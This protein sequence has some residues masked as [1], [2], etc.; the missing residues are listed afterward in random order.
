MAIFAEVTE[1]ECINEHVYSHK[2]AQK[3]VQ[4]KE[5]KKKVPLDFFAVTLPN[6]NRSSK[7][8]YQHTQQ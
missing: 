7:F 3:K 4:K 1:N 8:F 6:S 5:K 2:A